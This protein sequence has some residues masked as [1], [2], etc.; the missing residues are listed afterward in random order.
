MIIVDISNLMSAC[1]FQVAKPKQDLDAMLLKHS[2]LSSLMYLTRGHS[3]VIIACDGRN[4]WRKTV[5]KYYKGQRG[6][7]RESSGLP[8]PEIF[9]VF[10]ETI[11]ILRKY[12]PFR[13][14]QVDEAEADDVIFSV[15]KNLSADPDFSDHILI[16][17]SDKDLLQIQLHCRPG[18]ISQYSLINKKN[19]TENVDEIRD[20]YYTKLR[21]G[22]RGDGVPGMLS[23]DDI[24]MHVKARQRPITKAIVEATPNIETMREYALRNGVSDYFERNYKMVSFDC[25]PVDIINKI[26]DQ[27][28]NSKVA[29]SSM[30]FYIFLLQNGFP[31]VASLV[32]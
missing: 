27:F 9:A 23:P 28:R 14:L 25:V 8:W 16:A 4:N 3:N 5:F 2:I 24:F 13:V 31:R 19:L 17:S 20:I 11:E 12:S 6:T 22:D 7:N 26:V 1:A 32:R 18:L 21:K 29:G 15:C 30:D 10:A